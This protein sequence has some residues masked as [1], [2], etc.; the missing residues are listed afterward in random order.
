M[1]SKDSIILNA[2]IC[3]LR[4]TKDC[5]TKG[6]ESKTINKCY[7]YK[8]NAIIY[9]IGIIYH[10]DLHHMVWIICPVITGKF[11]KEIHLK[12]SLLHLP[13]YKKVHQKRRKDKEDLLLTGKCDHIG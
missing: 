10:I 2:R 6:Y 8:W 3:C 1:D 4:Y 13:K 9:R 5:N 12:R 11:W 7:Y